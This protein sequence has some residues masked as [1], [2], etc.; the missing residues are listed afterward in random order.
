[1]SEVTEKR[2]VTELKALISEHVRRTGSP[3]GKTIMD[4]FDGY[5]PKFKKIIP[6]DYERM[7]NAVEEL[8]EK[9]VS[10]E[11]ATMQA[12]YALQRS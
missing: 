5:L 4:N 6:K 2:D 12:F 11:E 7:L 1:M 10:R 9:G 8:E 3:F